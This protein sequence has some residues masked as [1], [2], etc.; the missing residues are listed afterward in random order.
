MG[1]KKKKKAY[2]NYNYIRSLFGYFN[3]LFLLSKKYERMLNQ[4]VSSN[5]PQKKKRL[6]FLLSTNTKYYTMKTFKKINI[7]EKNFLLSMNL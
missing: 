7:R 6:F 3:L 2:P 5:G 4:I 1:S